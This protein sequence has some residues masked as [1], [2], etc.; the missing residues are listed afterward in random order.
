MVDIP[1]DYPNGFN[2]VV[3]ILGS[4]DQVGPHA[5]V[6]PL[7]SRSA[8]GE[9]NSPPKFIGPHTVDKPLFSRSTTG[10]FNSPPKFI[11]PHT[12]DKPLFSRSATGEFNSPPKFIGPHAVDKPLIRPVDSWAVVGCS[13][14]RTIGIALG[15]PQA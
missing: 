15:A 14:L 13:V 4:H 6:K 7:L 5:S 10:E 8:T 9:F 3:S 2:G 11:G 12:V 1:G